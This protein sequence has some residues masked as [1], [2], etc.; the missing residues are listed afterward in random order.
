M[1]GCADYIFYQNINFKRQRKEGR[2]KPLIAE[3]GRKGG[4]K[5][6]WHL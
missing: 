4:R 2:K 6:R 1:S 3:G 5:G